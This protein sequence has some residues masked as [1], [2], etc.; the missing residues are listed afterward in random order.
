MSAQAAG[1]SLREALQKYIRLVRL[2]HALFSLPLFISG[3][4]LAGP[5]HF[6][7]W[8]DWLLI[9][10]AGTSARNLALALNRYID[11]SI[12][13]GNPR[14]HMRELPA[15][16]LNEPQVQGFIALNLVL[17]AASAWLIAPICF[18]LG[19]IPLAIF[20]LYPFMKRF[21]ALCH[22]GV[23]AG[24]AMAPL[25]GY[26]AA[27]K[28]WPLSVPSWLLAGFTF[29]WVSGFDIIYAQADADFDRRSGVHSLPV[30]LGG[31]AMRVSAALHMGAIL[32]LLALW[33]LYFNHQSWLWL[34]TGAMAVLFFLQHMRSGNIEF[35]AFKLNTLVGFVMLAYVWVGVA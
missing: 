11:R 31:V 3:A 24:L 22:F 33:G 12:D 23:G 13:S 9:A 4:L 34:P 30:K 6:P 32:V 27:A 17:Y 15:G 28:A 20:A 5:G 18:Y 1:R 2:E 25:G 8:F 7:S 21:T 16:R 29:L 10:V 35:A 26:L 19:W 14:T